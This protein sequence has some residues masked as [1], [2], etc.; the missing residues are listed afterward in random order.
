MKKKP[1]IYEDFPVHIVI[2]VN[3][4]TLA[5][6]VAGAYI[7]FT[8]NLVTGILY[9]VFL[10]ILE[11][12][13]YREGCRY[14]FYYGKLCAFGKGMIAQL[15]FKK[16]EPKEFCK[17][18][19]NWKDFVPQIL[20]VAVPLVVGIAL[21]ISRGFSILI[22]LALIYPVLSWFAL[23]PIIYGKITC[24]HCKQGSICCPAL[25]FFTKGKNGQSK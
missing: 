12:Q 25:K 5:V 2:L 18:E 3:I 7:M 13:V 16:G 10:V 1:E 17:R 21:L 24:P 23:N 15:F 8:L 22:L 11:F 14:C 9:V 6:Y 4:L 19:L 20:V